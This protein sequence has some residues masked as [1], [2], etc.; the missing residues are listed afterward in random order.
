MEHISKTLHPIMQQIFDDFI[1][2]QK[3]Q[4]PDVSPCPGENVQVGRDEWAMLDCT[5]GEVLSHSVPDTWEAPG[6]D[7]MRD[8]KTC[9]GDG[10]V[11]D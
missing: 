6:Y 9:G 4:T 3:M 8:C 7:V 1:K 10:F 5:D 11:V 2:I